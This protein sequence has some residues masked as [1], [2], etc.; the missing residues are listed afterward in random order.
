M[1]VVYLSAYRLRAYIHRL[2]PSDPTSVMWRAVQEPLWLDAEQG[3]VR[4]NERLEIQ[5]DRNLPQE[6]LTPMGT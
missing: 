6:R 2:S 4:A 3:A 5:P 1:V